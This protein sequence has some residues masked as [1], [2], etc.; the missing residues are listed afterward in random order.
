MGNSSKITT[1]QKCSKLLHLYCWTWHFLILFKTILSLETQ[2]TFVR[3]VPLIR[4][5][6]LQNIQNFDIIWIL[7]GC[8]FEVRITMLSRYICL[9]VH[10]WLDWIIWMCIVQPCTELHIRCLL[11]RSW[12]YKWC[13]DLSFVIKHSHELTE[14]KHK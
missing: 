2:P 4:Y 10:I 8:Q 1:T 9:F 7:N 13:Q 6:E 12:V 3:I 14:S 11:H 5:L